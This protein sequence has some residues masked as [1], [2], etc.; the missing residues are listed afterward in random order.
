MIF[1]MSTR[2]S[3]KNC[4]FGEQSINSLSREIV[5]SDQEDDRELF[6]QF[7]SE[8]VHS[9]SFNLITMISIVLNFLSIY[10]DVL[11]QGKSSRFSMKNT[12]FLQGNNIKAGMVLIQL[13]QNVTLAL[14]LMEMLL[15]YI[16]MPETF[17]KSSLNIVDLTMILA[18]FILT[19]T[20]IMSGVGQIVSILRSIRCKNPLFILFSEIFVQ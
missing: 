10:V 13:V 11:L 6:R 8:I 1:E 3:G 16:V 2:T 20:E 9:V 18:S 5:R 14:F 12:R 15:K 19:N 7:L 17:F 4:C